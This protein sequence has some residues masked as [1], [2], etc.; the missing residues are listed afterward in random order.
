MASFEAEACREGADISVSNKEAIVEEIEDPRRRMV[1]AAMQERWP[2]SPSSDQTRG[3][4]TR[5]WLA[6]SNA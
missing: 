5:S 6:E 1:V 2:P 3:G 4:E